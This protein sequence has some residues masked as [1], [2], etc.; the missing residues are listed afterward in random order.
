MWLA[1]AAVFVAGACMARPP[2]AAVTTAAS[3]VRHVFIIVLE[4]KNYADTFESSTQDPYLRQILVPMGALLTQ[5]YGTGHVSLD[6]YISLISG[7]A[8]TRDTTDDC[9]PGLVGTA[10]NFNNVV[11]TGWAA[12]GQVVASGGCVYS[13]RVRTLVEQMQQVGLTWR[14]Y[15]EDMGND[16]ARERAT[17][18]HP[19]IGVGTDRTNAAEGP[20][21]AVPLG[22]AYATRH[23]PF[24]YFHS[25]IDAKS[26]AA[27]D[28]NLARLPQD[29]QQ[30]RTTPNLVFITPNLCNDGHDGAGTGAPG[31]TCAN[32]QPGGLTS[33]DQFLKTWVPRILASAA[34]RKDGL[35]IVTFDE[36]SFATPEM[37]K[38]PTT[39][40]T[41]ET[42]TYPGQTCCHQQPGPN[43]A[44]AP[45]RTLTVVDTPSLVVKLVMQNFG[46]DRIGAVMVSPFIVPGSRSAKPYNHY[47]LLRSLEDIFRVGGHL[48]YAAD[49][50]SSGYRLD[51]I[52]NDQAIFQ[53]RH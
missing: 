1:A 45:S 41:I 38:N 13:T 18:G 31:T 4:N 7:Q 32:G 50:P 22:D 3:R 11:Q 52:G 51:G 20:S 2:A 19:L 43:L 24:M 25:I 39:G 34:Y 16:P 37:A 23:N 21:A 30:L 36:S 42:I 28:V 35:L 5:Y 40:Q 9:L 33:S 14:G 8:A 15:M 17:C 27:N 10:G 12:Q 29:L 6:N 46:G 44:A 48:G 47:S 49:D 26:C 53:H